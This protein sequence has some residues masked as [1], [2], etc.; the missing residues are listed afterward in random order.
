MSS[1]DAV[2]SASAI[3]ASVGGGGAIVLALPRRVRS[4][5]HHALC[6]RRDILIATCLSRLVGHLPAADR[7][8]SI[9]TADFRIA[10]FTA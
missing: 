7:H 3:M 6:G 2:K 5:F 8:P 1:L 10:G 9:S 4:T